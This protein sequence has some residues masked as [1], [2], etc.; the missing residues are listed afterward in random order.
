[1]ETGKSQETL[2]SIGLQSSSV[3][4]VDELEDRTGEGDCKFSSL[5]GLPRFWALAVSQLHLPRFPNASRIMN[6]WVF[7][8][9]LGIIALTRFH[10]IVP[11]SVPCVGEDKW[12]VIVDRASLLLLWAL[13]GLYK[14]QEQCWRLL[15]LHSIKIMSSGIIWVS[16]QEVGIPRNAITTKSFTATSL[17]ST[18]QAFL[19]SKWIFFHYHFNRFLWWTWFSWCY[20]CL[21]YRSHGYDRWHLASLLCGPASWWCARCFTSSKS[22]NP[23]ITPPTAQLWVCMEK[24]IPL[25]YTHI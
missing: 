4:E 12:V 8:S 6:L 21:L 13:S 16:L 15:E 22:S 24:F 1:M 2:E 14:V 11:A 23:S 18:I 25:S 7:Y 3:K 17:L 10:A 20:G 5:L 9:L 19:M